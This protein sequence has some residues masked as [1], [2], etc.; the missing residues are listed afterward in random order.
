MKAIV[1]VVLA[2][3]GAAAQSPQP[4]HH[5]VGDRVSSMW[6]MDG[7][8][9]TVIDT[10]TFRFPDRD[11]G[12]SYTIDFIARHLLNQP[13]ASPGVVDIVV[14]QHPVEDEAPAM[15][16]QADGEP[17]P[18]VTRLQARRSVVATVSLEEIDRLARA[19]VIVDR[20]FNTELEFGSG[21]LRWLRQ[22]ADSW[23]GRVR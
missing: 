10:A 12:P 21:Q 2:G 1:I 22:A 16:L 5:L 3:L 23:L 11:G 13:V 19:G 17:V 20:A 15:T 4:A 8:S 7:P 9:R 18:V 6:K 14:T